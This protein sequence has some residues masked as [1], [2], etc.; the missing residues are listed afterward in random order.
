MASAGYRIIDEPPPSPLKNAVANPF[1]IVIAGMV[2]PKLLVAALLWFGFNSFALAS[3]TR[4]QELQWLA[5]GLAVLAL[6]SAPAL[7]RLET[8][9]GPG[10]DGLMPYLLILKSALALAVL[11]RVYLFQVAPF[12]L[13]R[14]AREPGA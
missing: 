12:Q 2:L 3:P 1:W 14:H 13:H 9:F 5:G 7:A 6:F 8:W 10:S 4:R 11:F